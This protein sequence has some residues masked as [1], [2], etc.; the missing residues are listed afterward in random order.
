LFSSKKT[1]NRFVS[2][3]HFIGQEEPE[4]SAGA[5]DVREPFVDVRTS[6]GFHL[7]RRPSASN[8][9]ISK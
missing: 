5:T 8:K 9:A 2:T 4:R 6:I 1:R 7:N 3:T